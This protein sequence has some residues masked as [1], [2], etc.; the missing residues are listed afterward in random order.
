MTEKNSLVR[1]RFAPS[2]TGYLHI[3]GL[4][5]ALFNWLFAKH[6]NGSFLVRIEDTDI[7]RSKPEYKESILN[8]L[9]WA[10]LQ[11]DEQVLVQTTR[12][13]QHKALVEQL[14]T[15]KKAYK[16]FCSFSDHNQD[17][18][19]GK[20]NKKCRNLKEE[21]TPKGRSYAVRFKIPEDIKSIDFTDLIHGAISFDVDQIDDFIIMRSDGNPVYNFVVVADDAFMGISHVLRGED[22]ISNT[23]KQ[24]LIYQALNFKI[25]LFGHFPLILGADGTRLSKRHA[26]TSVIDYKNNGFL[27][28]ALCNYLVRLGWSHKDQE[29]FT[30]EELVQFF[31]LEN[32]GKK[33]SIFDINKLKWVNQVYIKNLDAISIVESILRDIDSKFVTILNGWDLEKI[34]NLILLYKDRVKT[35]KELYTKIKDLHCGPNDFNSEETAKWLN[36]E[37]LDLANKLELLLENTND[38]SASNLNFLLKEFCKSNQINIPVIAQPI[39]LALTGQIS[40][41]SIFELLAIL[42][43]EESLKRIIFLTK[44]L[45]KRVSE[46]QEPLI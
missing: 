15:E 27:P 7:E 8:S 35:I 28:D 39:R 32:V 20:Y 4:R 10:N 44:F 25:P 42:G 14:L 36:Q 31:D 9:V 17:L 5:T 23:P 37:S 19:F 34:N 33:N 11:S 29:L 38:F 40:S 16:C 2:P 24:I 30:R 12:V 26:A 3:G 43:K 18:E 22:H 46:K 21:E 13:K 6:Y 45:K 1:V 41:P